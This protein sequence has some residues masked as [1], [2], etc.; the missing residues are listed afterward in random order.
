VEAGRET[1][2]LRLSPASAED[3]HPPELADPVAKAGRLL[4]L[5]LARRGLHLLR[6]LRDLLLDRPVVAQGVTEQRQKD[7]RELL[8]NLNT[9]DHAMKGDPRLAAMAQCE[10]EAYDLILGD[11]GKVFELTQ[12][13]TELRERYGMTVLAIRGDN[14][15]YIYNPGPDEKLTVG[16]TLVVLG[17]AE[18]VASLRKEMA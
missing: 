4:E 3:L 11:A 12:E 5:Q 15:D 9:L 16:T 8:H 7:R 18:Q 14:K 1:A 17:S 13:K 2:P 10:K 6:Q